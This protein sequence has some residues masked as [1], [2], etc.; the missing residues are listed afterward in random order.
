MADFLLEST[1]RGARSQLVQSALIAENAKY[2][3]DQKTLFS[4]ADDSRYSTM[5]SWITT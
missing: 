5:I 4:V 3:A 2:D 1:K